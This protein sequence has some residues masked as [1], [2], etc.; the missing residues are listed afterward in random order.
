MHHNS[1]KQPT[2]N[3][4]N[5]TSS[6]EHRCSNAALQ[7]ATRTHSSIHSERTRRTFGKSGKTR[8]AVREKNTH[9]SSH[10]RQCINT[11]PPQYLHSLSLCRNV[12]ISLF[13]SCFVLS[14][15]VFN[16]SP[17]E[18][19]L[20]TAVSREI[21]ACWGIHPLLRPTLLHA[22]EVCL[23]FCLLMCNIHHVCVWSACAAHT[24]EFFSSPP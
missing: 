19:P 20:L 5:K 2:E 14:G 4:E 23:R 21:A 1:T 8:T 17:L 10:V 15:H 7:T 13:F 16:P 12:F 11:S 6:S 9:R 3:A 24:S 18:L 22:S